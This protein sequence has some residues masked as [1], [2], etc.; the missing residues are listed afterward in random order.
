[1]MIKNE[2]EINKYNTTNTTSMGILGRSEDTENWKM[3]SYDTV[4]L[5]YV[6]CSRLS[7]GEVSCGG[8]CGQ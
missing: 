5:N 8:I 1:M 7:P 3:C 4:Q 6:P 2:Y